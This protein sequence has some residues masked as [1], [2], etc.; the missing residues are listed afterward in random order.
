MI[1]V[2]RYIAIRILS[3]VRA[4]V[5]PQYYDHVDT[6]NCAATIGVEEG[7]SPRDGRRVSLH[8]SC[9]CLSTWFVLHVWNRQ[10]GRE[11]PKSRRCNNYCLCPG[12]TFV[13]FA[14]TPTYGLL[15]SAPPPLLVDGAL[16][17]PLVCVQVPCRRDSRCYV[18]RQCSLPG[19]RVTQGAAF[20]SGLRVSAVWLPYG[21]F[22]RLCRVYPR[23][24]RRDMPRI[25]GGPRGP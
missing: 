20:G 9:T 23:R 11:E 6:P 22:T 18:L 13:L 8:S 1:H 15:L 25:G 24:A 16:R 4:Q 12:C 7:R 17:R 5:L 14:S 21:L 19:V 2:L 3:E 10:P